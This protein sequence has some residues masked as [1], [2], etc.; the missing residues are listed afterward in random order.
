MIRV[1]HADSHSCNQTALWTVS[2]LLTYYFYLTPLALSL[3]ATQFFNPKRA[4]THTHVLNVYLSWFNPSL[5]LFSLQFYL[6]A[7]CQSCFIEVA[8]QIRR[9]ERERGVEKGAV[10]VD[11]SHKQHLYEIYCLQIQMVE[12]LGGGGKE[13]EWE[14]SEQC[15]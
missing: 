10:Q 13:K 14:V 5:I 11:R 8:A 9:A 12:R 7:L 6:L 4:H 15:R 3:A 1:N 2:Y